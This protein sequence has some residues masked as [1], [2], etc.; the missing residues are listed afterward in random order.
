MDRRQFLAASGVGVA[1]AVAGCM[2][3]VLGT[4]AGPESNALVQGAPPGDDPGNAI[5]VGGEAE[6]EVD[7]DKATLSVG[8]EASGESAEAVNDELR[9]DAEALR[10]AFEDLEIPEENVESG[11]FDVRQ[12]HRGSGFEGAHS[13]QVELDDPDR[14]GEVIDATIAAGADDVGYVRFGLQEETREKLRDE[15]LDE[16]LARADSEA[17]HI[18]A[19]RGV[20]IT[21]TRSVSTSDVG[22]QPVRTSTGY[23]MAEA[24]D[25]SAPPTEIESGPVRVT[26][27][28]TVAYSFADADD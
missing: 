23:E 16:A 27:S 8:V 22:V 20:E 3:G 4:N 11:R 14:V 28:V 7:P 17:A 2:N 12:Q 13:F 9:T 10:A 19:N 26:A 25:G 15:A 24:D 18:A 21:G 1:A 5:Q 6:V